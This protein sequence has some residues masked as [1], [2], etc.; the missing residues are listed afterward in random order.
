MGPQLV[1]TPGEIKRF[2]ERVRKRGGVTLPELAKINAEERTK[3]GFSYDPQ[4]RRWVK[5]STPPR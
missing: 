5:N 1:S 2:E 4:N 3:A